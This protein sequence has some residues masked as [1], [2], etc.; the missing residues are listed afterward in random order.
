MCRAPQD[1][2]AAAQA[3]GL[4]MIVK[5]PRSIVEGRRPRRSP[6]TLVVDD[7][8]FEE[9]FDV[10]PAEYSFGPI[11]RFVVGGWYSAPAVA[12]KIAGAPAP[13][14]RVAFPR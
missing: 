4:P 5:G 14:L 13:P 9:V 6:G 2:Q 11:M 8:R 7:S 12:R 3:F 1:V 10:A